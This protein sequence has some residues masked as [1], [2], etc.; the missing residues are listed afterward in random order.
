MTVVAVVVFIVLSFSL[1]ALTMG[2]LVAA[3]RSDPVNTE[4]LD[5][6]EWMSNGG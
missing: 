2:I 5:V 3:S 1:G 4:E 6:P